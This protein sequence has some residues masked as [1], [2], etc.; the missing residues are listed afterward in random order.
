MFFILA[1]LIY[2]VGRAIGWLAL[3]LAMGREVFLQDQ[4]AGR[5][6]LGLAWLVLSIVLAGLICFS[7]TGWG[8]GLPQ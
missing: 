3:S 4:P 5:Q 8:F 7:R 2:G 1:F 6:V